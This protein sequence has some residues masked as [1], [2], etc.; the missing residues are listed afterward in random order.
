M[1]EN[2]TS[3]PSRSRP[4]LFLG[5]VPLR[6]Q[7]RHFALETHD[8]ELLGH[9]AMAQ[10]KHAA[11]PR[12]TSSPNRVPYGPSDREERILR[13]VIALTKSHDC[14]RSI[15]EGLPED[16]Q[17]LVPD[18]RALD[19]GRVREIQAHP[20]KKIRAYIEDHEPEPRASNQKIAD[21]L[22]TFGLR[23]PRRRRHQARRPAL[24]KMRPGSP[25]P[26]MGPGT[27]WGRT[28]RLSLPHRP[29][30]V[31]SWGVR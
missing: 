30:P 29:R 21:A 3:I 6:L 24:A 18:L 16:S 13:H 19:Y 12:T 26:A 9:L 15:R 1:K 8:L 4:R 27:G 20:L 23:V 28:L 7:P 31:G 11:D 10:G 14:Y 22:A 2:F 17:H 25:A 5:Y